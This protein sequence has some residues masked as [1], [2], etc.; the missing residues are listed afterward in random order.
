LHS[1]SAMHRARDHEQESQMIRPFAN[2]R[3]ST[4]LLAFV[5]ALTLATLA[6]AEPAQSGR[7]GAPASSRMVGIIVKLQDDPVVSYQG[8]TPGLAATSREA[9]RT[10]KSGRHGPAVQ[11]YRA[12]LAQKH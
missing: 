10:A 12:H 6:S 11:A 9:L 4:G 2:C 5:A 7:E 1:A 8:T 3:A